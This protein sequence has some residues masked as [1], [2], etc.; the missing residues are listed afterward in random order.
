MNPYNLL[1][2]TANAGRKEIQSAYRRFAIKYHPDRTTVD[3]APRLFAEYSEAYEILSDPRLRAVYD[4]YGY[5]GLK[6]IQWKPTDASTVF[7]NFFG[8]DNP[9]DYLLPSRNATE[10][11]QL[12]KPS[13]PM[14]NEPLE[15]E[16]SVPLSDFI[17]G[18]V[19]MA[20]A[21]RRLLHGRTEEVRFACKVHPGMAD[22][23]RMVFPGLGHSDQPGSD[24]AD[25]IVTVLTEP[26][27]LYARYGNDLVY[28]QN[29][30][31]TDALLGRKFKVT[32]M[33]GRVLPLHL[34]DI[35]APGYRI[36][37][38]GEGVPIWNDVHSEVIGKGD[39]YVEFKVEWPINRS[40]EIWGSLVST[41]KAQ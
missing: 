38:S 14:P 23:T 5:T 37:I 32:L 20:T 8:S 41:F 13:P 30:T 2:I 10:F 29:M 31:L 40:D 24:P 19:R 18:H 21:V 28:T 17:F 34:T 35:S 36:C 6:D 39:L 16:L 26:N 7:F 15:I 4:K 27:K 12:T 33:D 25:A 11:A 22:G 9:F 1:G 3:E